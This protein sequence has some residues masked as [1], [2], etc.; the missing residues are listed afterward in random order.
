MTAA[1]II[2]A[3]AV[4]LGTLLGFLVARIAGATG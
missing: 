4:P 2:A 1:H 3:V